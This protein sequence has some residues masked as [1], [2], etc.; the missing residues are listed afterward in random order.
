MK[1]LEWYNQAKAERSKWDSTFQEVGRYVWPNAKNIVKSVNVP[2]EGQVLTVDIAD[3]TAIKLSNRMTAGIV[4]YLM[5]VG[6]KWFEFKPRD[7]RLRNDRN[8]LTKLSSATEAV[9]TSIWRSNFLREIYTTV[10]SMVVFGTGC[11]SVEMVDNELVYRAYHIADIFFELNSKGVIDVVFRRMFYNARQMEQEFGI[12]NLPDSVVQ[13][14]KNKDYGQKYEVVHAV[15]PRRNYDKR[16][17][18][19]KGKPF[20]SEWICVESKTMLKEGGFDSMPYKIGRFEL[21]PDEIMG[22]SPAIELLPDIKML[23]DMRYTFVESSEKASNPPIVIED[24]GVVSQP[25][26]GPGDVIVKRQGAEDPHPLQ[27]GANPQLTAEVVM[28]ERQGLS[29]G[30]A[31]DLFQSL[32]NYRNMTATEVEG[33]REEKMVMI[34][35]TITGLQK[36]LLDPLIIRTLHLLEEGGE[37]EKLDVDVDVTYQGRLALAM[38]NMQT[39]AIELW[40]AKW[41]PYQQYFPVLDNVNIDEGAATSALNMG[42]PAHLIRTEDEVSEVREKTQQAQE[43]KQSAELMETGSKAI[44]N[45]QGT[46]LEGMI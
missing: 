40:V 26:T 44:R 43:A 23:N 20:V 28:Q 22:R 2:N 24:D 29:E 15:Y 32:A 42:V 38:S 9:H 19:A 10:R 7:Y 41:S 8:I 1:T 30:F 25:A 45:L 31:N 46:P 14:L 5:P 39:N 13:N 21:S 17:K 12:D 18:D 11:L 35:P 37:V 6:V 27:T 34:A 3:S 33:R 16:K 4:S 36:E